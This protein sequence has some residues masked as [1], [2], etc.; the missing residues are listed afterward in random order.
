MS[1][2]P[3]PYGFAFFCLFPLLLVGLMEDDYDAENAEARL[4]KGQVLIVQKE[5]VKARQELEGYL[6]QRPTT[7][8]RL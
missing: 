4:L 2:R 5:F 3:S 6:K 1:R 7:K 8:P